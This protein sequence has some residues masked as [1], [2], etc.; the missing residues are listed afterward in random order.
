MRPDD[1]LISFSEQR[2]EDFVNAR[3]QDVR[4]LP[5]GRDQNPFLRIASGFFL[6]VFVLANQIVKQTVSA[7]DQLL[8]RDA[9]YFFDLTVFPNLI[10]PDT[11]DRI[12]VIE[13]MFA[14][15]QMNAADGVVDIDIFDVFPDIAFLD[16]EIVK[17]GRCHQDHVRIH[18]HHHRDHASLADIIGLELLLRFR[19]FKDLVVR[20]VRDIMDRDC[21]VAEQIFDHSLKILVKSA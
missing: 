6:H 16:V 8:F 3:V 7:R 11:Q 13:C 2:G 12:E 14:I 18:F 17:V 9:I 1:D 10:L 4:F 21:R 19:K 15:R 20:I 5:R